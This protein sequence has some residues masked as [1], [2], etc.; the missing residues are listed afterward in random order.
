[1][2]HNAMSAH[3]IFFI[4]PGQG[5]Q[6]KGMGSDLVR[7]FASAREIYTRASA[8]VGYDLAQLSFE[9]PQN[10]LGQTRYTQP[11]LLTH[12]I[13]CLTVLRELVGP[14]GAPAMTAGHSLG[15]Y[16]ALVCAGALT[17]ER[18]LALVAERG[19]LMSEHGRGSMLATTL[20]LEPAWELADKHYCGIGGCNLPDQTVIAGDGADLDALAEDLAKTHPGKRGVRLNTEG[21]FHTYFMITAA[22]M[23]RGTLRSTQFD[24]I[25]VEVL[26]NYTGKPH[27]NDPDAIR[28]RLFFQL[29]H[30]VRWVA[31]M[32]VAIDAGVDTIVEIGGG[33][34]KGDTP[35]D[36]R[37][38]LESIVK[39]SLKWRQREA[40]YL[41]AI[42]AGG[43][44]AAAEQLIKPA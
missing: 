35:D 44:R 21:A 38:N 11:A 28:S 5:S 27:I 20:E 19:R 39:K 1:M 9:D 43:I 15:E 8:V 29:F 23:F 26:S 13:A 17:F 2:K 14:G 30:A 6:Y 31:C 24:Q 32:N 22:L 12:E 3:K 37:P 36:K 7:E 4:F 25:K 18:A 34:G 40:Q 10:K 42:N 41:P 33:I 16:A